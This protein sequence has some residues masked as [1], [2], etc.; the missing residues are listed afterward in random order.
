MQTNTQNKTLRTTLQLLVIGILAALAVAGCGDMNVSGSNG[1]GGGISG[2]GTIIGGIGGGGTGIVTSASIAS[3][4]DDSYGNRSNLAHALVFIDLNGNGQPD[5]DEPTARTDQQ[6]NYNLPEASQPE[7]ADYP[8][9]ILAVADETT[10]TVTGQTVTES[11]LV[12]LR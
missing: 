2:G 10:D 9:Y 12:D 6:G 3:I 11:Y 5:Q 1:T 4:R 8:V 7:Y